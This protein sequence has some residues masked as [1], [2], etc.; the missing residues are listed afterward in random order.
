L[1]FRKVA[2]AGPNA[3]IIG[4]GLIASGAILGGFVLFRRELGVALKYGIRLLLILLGVAVSILVLGMLLV[5][6]GLL[7]SRRH[8]PAAPEHVWRGP[9]PGRQPWERAQGPAWPRV[10]PWTDDTI[11]PGRFERWRAGFEAVQFARVRLIGAAVIA[12]ADEL[13][14]R[15]G[16]L[17]DPSPDRSM[18]TSIVHDRVD[19]LLAPVSDLD[20]L[21]AKIDFGTVADIDRQARLITV[22]V[23]SAACAKEGGK[24]DRSR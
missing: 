4:Y 6:M 22:T 21:A 24:S 5:R 8:H 12:R 18:S 3:W 17:R 9:E 19:V 11:K 20:G 14:R 2:P 15:L 16:S 10:P 13:A 23:D 1:Q 7:G